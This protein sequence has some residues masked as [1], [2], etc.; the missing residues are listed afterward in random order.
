MPAVA[1][2][3]QARITLVS[4]SG[5]RTVPAEDFFVG[6][7]ETAIGETEVVTEVDYPIKGAG[8]GTGISEFA[9]RHGDFAIAGAT[10]TL[11]LGDHHRVSDARVVLFGVGPRPHRALL[12]EEYLVG[13]VPDEATIREA[14]E[15][16]LDGVVP[17]EDIHGGTDYR[18]RIA[19]GQVRKALT[20]ARERAAKGRR[21]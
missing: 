12:A 17:Q 9:R 2:A 5:Q 21:Q 11:E 18:I 7:F 8:V 6:P 13:T 19:R 20:V 4:T 14:A 15:L 10:A 16:A 3:L 1:L